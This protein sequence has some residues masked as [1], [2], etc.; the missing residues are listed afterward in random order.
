MSG[1]EWFF[2]GWGLLALGL[3]LRGIVAP[4]KAIKYRNRWADR[5]IRWLTFG[6]VKKSFG[7]LMSEEMDIRITFYASVALLPRVQ[8]LSSS[9]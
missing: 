7:P 3:G 8:R 6:R 1:N 5:S 2:L 9:C 4:E